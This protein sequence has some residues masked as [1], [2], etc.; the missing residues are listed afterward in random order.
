M[1]DSKGANP[2]ELMPEDSGFGAEAASPAAPPVKR[3]WRGVILPFSIMLLSIGVL[4]SVTHYA[5]SPQLEH[6]IACRE[7]FV[8][9][10]SLLL[11]MHHAVGTPGFAGVW[12]LGLLL[13]CWQVGSRYVRLMMGLSFLLCALAAAEGLAAVF[14]LAQRCGG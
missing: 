6:W 14:L 5:V 8:W 7:T 13:L 3:D 11:V 10:S 9:P 2:D 4:Y 12:A 1:D